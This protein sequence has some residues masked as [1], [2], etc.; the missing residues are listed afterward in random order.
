MA[1]VNTNFEVAAKGIKIDNFFVK[2]ANPELVKNKNGSP[3]NS[4]GGSGGGNSSS[5]FSSKNFIDENSPPTGIDKDPKALAV[6]N[7]LFDSECKDS[8]E[9][10]PPL[11]P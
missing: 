7:D 8:P 9:Y 5:I 11:V 4:S 2:A 3:N 10:K 6:I 1:D